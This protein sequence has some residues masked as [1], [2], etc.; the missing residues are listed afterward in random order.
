MKNNLEYFRG[1]ISGLTQKELAK[2]SKVC[3]TIIHRIESQEYVPNYTVAS[4]LAYYLGIT[5]K[6][7]FPYKKKERIKE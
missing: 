1:Y 3:E 6:D 2:K 4:R 5:V 7:I